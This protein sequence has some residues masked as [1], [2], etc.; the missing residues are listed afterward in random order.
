MKKNIIINEII[1][2]PMGSKKIIASFDNLKNASSELNRVFAHFG[3]NSE[4][5]MG[6][7]TLSRHKEGK[8]VIKY[9]IIGGRLSK[10][11]RAVIEKL[12]SGV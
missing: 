9:D 3:Y 5:I 12:L 6:K 8:S 4:K 7:I 11:D 2:T 1:T 10:E